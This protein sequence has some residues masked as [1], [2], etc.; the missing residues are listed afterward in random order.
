MEKI[1]SN[2]SETDLQIGIQ[3]STTTFIFNLLLRL[4]QANYCPPKLLR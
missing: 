1:L 4:T 2:K 3:L